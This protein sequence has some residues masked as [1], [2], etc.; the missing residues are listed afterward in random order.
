MLYFIIFLLLL[1]FLFWLI[2]F[3]FNKAWQKGLL[4][5]SL[6]FVLLE[7]R[8]PKVLE[9][10]DVNKEKE[11]LLIMEQFYNS[12]GSILH[13]NKGLFSPKPYLIFE[14]AVPEEGE[15]IGFYF[16]LP[17][18]FQHTITRQIQGFFPEAEIE[19]V[20][21]FNIFN[22]QGITKSAVLKPKHN[23]LSFQTYKKLEASTLDLITGAISSLKEKGEG[24]AFQILVRPIKQNLFEVNIRILVS[25]ETEEVADQILT[26]I[27]SAFAQFEFPDLNSFYS[28]RPQGNLLKK[29]IYNFSFRLFNKKETIWLSTEEL[30]SIFHWP[31]IKIETPKVRF[32]KAKT[33]GPPM[34]LPVAGIILG[35]NQFRGQET[36]IKLNPLDRRRHL[37][38]LGQINTGKNQLLRNL[39]KQDIDSNAGVGVIDPTGD[40]TEAVLSFAPRLR[41]NEIIMVDAAKKESSIDFEDIINNGKILLVKSDSSSVSAIIAKLH[42]ATVKRAEKLGRL[43]QRDFYLYLNLNG[44]HNFTANSIPTILSEFQKYHI[45]LTITDEDNSQLTEETRDLILNNAG[46][47]LAFRVGPKTA[48]LLVKHFEPV[49]NKSDLINID[50]HHA[51]AKLLINGT[52][53]APF[54]IKIVE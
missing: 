29:L 1:A 13:K 18:K 41:H 48:K 54:N 12:L 17:K 28:F 19:T 34:T 49:F 38:I 40:L 16:A 26:N 7:I 22:K 9:S 27:E 14:I 21:D 24:A 4:L 6:N 32:L 47:L 30:T 50:E 44:L 43:P 36:V 15:E 3:L 53:T 39:I 25:A 37:Y 2:W 23:T 10:T 42:E 5:S 20:N 45:N 31:I 51:Y 8:F 11:K 35:K 52:F 33:A 46:S